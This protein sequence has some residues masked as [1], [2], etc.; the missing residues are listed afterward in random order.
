MAGQ[1]VAED[2]LRAARAVQVEVDDDAAGTIRSG[3]LASPT[4][5]SLVMLIPSLRLRGEPGSDGDP[6]A[7]DR[8][9]DTVGERRLR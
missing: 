2:P 8:E 1:V 3:V 9:D 6:A 4:T 7:V 5:G